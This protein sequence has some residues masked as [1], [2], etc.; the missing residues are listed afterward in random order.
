M[1]NILPALTISI[2]IIFSGCSNKEDKKAV[3]TTD[4]SQPKTLKSLENKKRTKYD[5]CDCN[6]RSQK[7]IDDAITTRLK[8]DS[9]KE[10][11]ADKQSKTKVHE[12]ATSYI[13][14]AKKC[15]EVNNARLMIESECNNLK[16]LETKKD[17]L[18]KLGIQI[19]L[20]SKK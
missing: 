12:L 5:P 7:I 4:I 6:E 10:L 13:E 16:L 14:L 2:L 8:F 1:K 19:E 9:V 3:S 15:F 11:K 17:S 20:W 18:I